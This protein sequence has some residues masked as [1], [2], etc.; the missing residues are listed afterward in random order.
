MKKREGG[1]VVKH[2]KS[3]GQGVVTSSRPGG[4]QGALF[5]FS[6]S[7]FELTVVLPR[8]GSSK[9]FPNQKSILSVLAMSKARQT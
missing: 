5:Q 7:L 9:N 2:Q 3:K 1:R 6:I 8:S 4:A